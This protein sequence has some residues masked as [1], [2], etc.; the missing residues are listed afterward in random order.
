MSLEQRV[1]QRVD[2]DL[3]A[4]GPGRVCDPELVARGGEELHRCEAR[5]EDHGDIDV[6]WQLL[7]QGAADGGLPCA[8]LAREQHEASSP[9][10]PV[11]QMGECLAVRIAQIEVAWVRREGER[12]LREPEV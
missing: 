3:E 4:R 11:E 12:P 9:A 1:G 7:E 2:Q 6:G 5:I 8:D 10:D